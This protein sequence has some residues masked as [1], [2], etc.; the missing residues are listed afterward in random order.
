MEIQLI[1][2]LKYTYIYIFNGRV[3]YFAMNPRIFNARHHL[4]TTNY[5]PFKITCVEKDPPITFNQVKHFFGV[6]KN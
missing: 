4:K 5:A 6:C 2:G 1:I 3:D